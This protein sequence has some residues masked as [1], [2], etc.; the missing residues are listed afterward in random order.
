MS[1]FYLYT[2]GGCTLLVALYSYFSQDAR[3][4]LPLPPG[5]TKWPVVGNLFDMPST[6]EWITF[7][8]WSRKYNSD[9]LHLNVAGQSII[10]LSSAKAAND[11]LEKKASIY[12]DRARLPMV[13]ELMGWD[14][15]LAFMKHGD[16]WR[17]HRKLFHEVFNQVAAQ[18]FRPKEKEVANELLND[19][20]ERP[21]HDP[22]DHLRHMAAKIV[23]SIAYG[24][25]VLPENDPY[26]DWADKAVEGLVTAIVPGRFLVD[27]F[28]FLKYVPEW[29]PGAGFQ[30]RAREWRRL[31]RGMLEKPFAA[32]RQRIASGTAPRSFTMDG[33]KMVEGAD[34]K[35]YMEQVVQATA[36]TMYT[37][38]TGTTVSA[39]GTFILSMLANPE[40]Q[41]KAQAEIDAVVGTDRLPDWE[42]EAKMPYL[43]AVIK[44]SL[45]WRN[46]TPIA[47]PHFLPVEDEYKGY[48]LPAGS[49]VMPNTW[50]I[51]HDE[52]MYPDPYSFKPERYLLDGK[53]NP[54]VMD[55]DMV[56]GFG[57]RICPGRHMAMSS[58][59][60]TI[61][62]ILAA[63]DITKAVDEKGQVIEPT[64]EYFAGLVVQPL[65][66]KC[67]IKPRSEKAAALIKASL[68]K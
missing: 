18:T 44:E 42:D 13:N 8:E 7:M 53:P 45:R 64:Y 9:I 14:F 17:A 66:F 37:A 67:S 50:A 35:V 3:S 24:I 63:F 68:E 48:R 62:R 36:G 5:P 15:A 10:V 65:P 41:K 2:L 29:V 20:L 54:A 30:R 56:F 61:A 46:V 28:P 49:I 6:F 22:L 52:E 47:I 38:G 11:L 1:D 27:S 26:V 40:A 4:K 23:I 34:N 31:A 55:P 60:I 25:D 43:T 33:L 58:V 32:A 19:F 59:W 12:S 16:H 21:D 57:R 39:I 51:L